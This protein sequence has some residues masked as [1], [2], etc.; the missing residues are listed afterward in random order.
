VD[1][2]LPEPRSITRRLAWAVAGLVIAA[3]VS[4][5]LVNAREGRDDRIV[6]AAGETTS[7]IEATTTVL[8]TTTVMERTTAPDRT[9][10]PPTTVAPTP[11]SSTTRLPRTTTTAKAT[12]TTKVTTTSTTKRPANA[13]TVTV[14]NE[15]SYAVTVAMNGHSFGALAPGQQTAPFVLA[16]DSNGNDSIGVRVVDAPGCGV[17]DAGGLIPGPGQYRV[18]IIAAPP[19]T[20]LEDPTHPFPGPAFQIERA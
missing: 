14:V 19:N 5:V 12:T 11:T 4:A 7:G 1:E 10:V 18:R 3:M 9:T 13:A 15:Y 8:E 20:C 2:E 16:L 17:G 6:S